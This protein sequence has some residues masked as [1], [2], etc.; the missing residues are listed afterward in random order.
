MPDE[1]MG[2]PDMLKTLGTV[3]A[4]L[5]TVPLVAGTELT[6]VVPLE[7]NTLPLVLGATNVG[8]DVPLPSMTLLAV[9]VASPVPPLFTSRVPA[10]TTAPE[11]AVA[12]VRPVA[13]NDMELRS[14]RA[15]F[16]VTPLWT[17]GSSSVPDTG[18]V[19]AGSWEIFTSAITMLLI[20]TQ[21][22]IQWC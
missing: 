16:L 6:Q 15:I 20:R 18:V 19:A 5:V 22:Y 3:I 2:L 21:R 7:V 14:D 17:K 12:G 4:T 9:R 1:V 10:T 13:P 8:A 11:V